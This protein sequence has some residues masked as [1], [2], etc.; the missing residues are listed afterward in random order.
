MYYNHSQNSS[1]PRIGER[2]EQGPRGPLFRSSSLTEFSSRGP[3]RS[4][5][6]SESLGGQDVDNLKTLRSEN[7]FDRNVL[8]DTMEYLMT[9]IQAVTGGNKGLGILFED[10]MSR[11][12]PKPCLR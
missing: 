10:G 4:L 11:G 9:P 8:C 1:S 3:R 12:I 5:S 7:I 6:D 2:H